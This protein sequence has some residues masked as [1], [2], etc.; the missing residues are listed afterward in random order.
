MPLEDENWGTLSTGAYYCNG[1]NPNYYQ[2]YGY[3]YNWHAVNTGK[4][5][6]TGWHVPTQTEW[7]TLTTYLKDNLY[8][9]GGSGTNIAKS[10]ASKSGWTYDGTEG[11]VGND[12][13]N[14]KTSGFN[15]LPGGDCAYNGGFDNLL[16]QGFLWSSTERGLGDAYHLL[17]KWDL[18]YE[19]L[20]YAD[21]R[22]GMS[23]RCLRN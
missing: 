14:Y 13:E 2:T 23:V 17:V 20:L 3:L 4:L 18:G 11:N 22:S 12:Q 7:T 8:G 6:P 16:Y 9:Y 19:Q 15:I 10:M 5:C 1:S 21:K